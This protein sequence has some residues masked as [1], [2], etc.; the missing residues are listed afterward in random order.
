MKKK[1]MPNDIIDDAYE[2]RS[3]IG[4]MN[5]IY[6]VESDLRTLLEADEI[7]EDKK[8]MN[9]VRKLAKDKLED[10]AKIS[11]LADVKP[12]KGD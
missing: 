11:T 7:R 1:L 10:L 3:G 5:D 9:A 2:S 6:A 12:E 4:A 8:R